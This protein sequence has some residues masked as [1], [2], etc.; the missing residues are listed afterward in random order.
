MD[1]MEISVQAFDENSPSSAL[2]SS[3]DLLEDYWAKFQSAQLNVEEKLMDEDLARV[4]E[5][6][7]VTE[8]SYLKS[9]SVLKGFLERRNRQGT[10]NQN[11]NQNADAG[12][13]NVKL[14]KLEVPTFDGSFT[15]WATFRD[16]FLSMV[17]NKNSIT[18][19]EKLQY[20]KPNCKGEAEDIVSEYQITDANYQGAWAALEERFDNKRLQVK[21]HLNQ[22]FGQPVMTTENVEMLRT[23]LRTTQKCLRALKSLGGPVEAWDWLLVHTTVMRLDPKTRRYWELIHTSKEVATWQ[24]LV[25]ALDNRCTALESESPSTKVETKSASSSTKTNDKKKVGSPSTARVLTAVSTKVCAICNGSHDCSN[26]KAFLDKNLDG[27]LDLV[28][29]HKLC[30]KCLKSNHNFRTCT[31]SRCGKCNKRHHQLLHDPSPSLQDGRAQ[32]VQ[33]SN[34][35]SVSSQNALVS[36]TTSTDLNQVLLSTALVKVRTMDGNWIVLRAFLDGGAQRNV[37][38]EDCVQ[39]LGLQRF[40]CNV[41]VNG[42][43]GVD[44]GTFKKGAVVPIKSCVDDGYRLSINAVV[45]KKIT[46][47]LPN[48]QFDISKWSYIRGL[49]LADP[50]FNEPGKID[51]LIGAEFFFSLLKNEP[52]VEGPVGYPIAQ[53]T[54]LGW[55]LSGPVKSSDG[56]ESSS[57]F[58]LTEAATAQ[59]LPAVLSKF[60]EL[61]EFPKSTLKSI[62]D[63]KCEEHFENTF[64]RTVD[65]RFIVKLPFKDDKLEFGDTRTSA[66]RRFTSLERRFSKDQRLQSD[67]IEQIRELESFAHAKPIDMV[68][69]NGFYLPHHAVVKPSRTTTKTRIVFDAAAKDSNGVSLNDK[70]MVG[71]RLQEDLLKL[72][73]RFRRHR[74]AVS[75]DVEKMF[76]Q[77]LV[78]LEDQQF[79]RFLWRESLQ[80]VLK[81]FILTTVVFGTSSAPF[82]AVKVLQKLAAL[83]CGDLTRTRSVILND[84]FMDD[85]LS[86][87]DTSEDVIQLVSELQS[88]LAKGKFPL[89]KWISNDN[90][91]LQSIDDDLK[92]YDNVWDVPLQDSCK[93]LGLRW[94]PGADVFGYQVNF[95]IKNVPAT[96]RS[97][98]SVI[99]S[100]YDPLG[101]LAPTVVKAKMIMQKIWR[102]GVDWDA[103]VSD[104][105]KAEWIE[106]YGGLNKINEIVVPR[107][108]GSYS[109]KC[110]ELHGFSDASNEAYSAVVYSRMKQDDGDYTTNI[111]IAKTRV[112][113][114]KQITT[115]HLE[116][117]GALL[118]TRLLS[119]AVDSLKLDK[120]LIFAWCDNTAV[121]DWLRKE[122]VYWKTFVA[123][124]VSEIQ[125]T[126]PSLSWRYVPSDQNPADCASRGIGAPTLQNHELWRN[127]PLWPNLVP[128]TNPEAEKEARKHVLASPVVVVDDRID[129]LARKFS[130]LDKSKNVF[131]YVMRFIAIARGEDKRFMG[132]PTVKELDD[133]LKFM[134]SLAQR[135]HFSEQLDALKVNGKL[136][137]KDKLL[138]LNPFI[139]NDGLLRV[140]GRLSNS[141]LKY[142]EKF[143]IIL[144]RLDHLTNMIIRHCHLVNF[145]AGTTL[146]LSQLRRTYWIVSARNLVKQYTRKCVKCCRVR[147]RT[148][149]QMMGDLPSVRVTS[150][151]PFFRSSVDYAGPI[152][153]KVPTTNVRKYD[154]T[155]GYIAVFICLATKCIHLEVVSDQT[156]EKY[157]EAYKRFTARRGVAREM[158]SDNGL[159]FV[160]AKNE[161]ARLK[162]M[163]NDQVQSELIR[164][165]LANDGT[166]W[167]MVPPY[168]PHFNGLCEAAVKS[169]KFHLH[170]ILSSTP[171]TFKEMSTILCQIEAILNSRPLIP[172]SDDVNDL[173]VLTPGHFLIGDQ[174]TAVPEPD[175][176]HIQMN[177]LDRFQL[178]Q[179]QVQE[180]WSKWNKDYLS[181]LQ[182][183]TKWKSPIENLKV[184]QLV[185]IKDDDS[186]P[187]K[188]LLA[189]VVK[190]KPGKDSRVRVAQLRTATVSGTVK[191][192]KNV[193]EMVAELKTH[194]GIAERSVNNLC[195]LPLD[196][197]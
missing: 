56:S 62:E 188:W 121:L 148:S 149:S 166:D 90:D 68:Q 1:R 124:R 6:M 141:L 26:C 2:Q 117:C 112:A 109:T 157:L 181:S 17:G 51:L 126:F 173:N 144:P 142:D 179:R 89:R 129:T 119:Y 37:V 58:V 94:H 195:I 135:K 87:G 114:I 38:T 75:A 125:S 134:I 147:G 86:G 57:L 152:Q 193:R 84:F 184:G 139:G 123:N 55:I 36:E 43:A 175:L 161:L 162:A 82:L 34:Q 158:R 116:L 74:V 145:H 168:T 29:K 71:P 52:Q 49:K 132:P 97:I 176:Q 7:Q 66:L 196:D 164:K 70:L 192:G 9:K 101:L 91:V 118:L 46:T 182:Q 136:K 61:E 47:D 78:A 64:S 154:I 120:T 8:A 13:G 30:Y 16:L 174:L 197:E 60:W 115:P 83:E 108:L 189:R 24:E 19:A 5:E 80:D 151:R 165:S 48:G 113:P 146:M 59:S 69:Q 31:E 20:L 191:P 155:K 27:R 99:A 15:N 128:P 100:L 11:R 137:K 171:F 98:L 177:R 93:A 133:A 150:H 25:T 107:W 194:Y 85:L 167:S 143:P 127:G 163:L 110:L 35:P 178:M 190:I 81:E 185:T 169:A 44:V 39:R 111:V 73:I 14:P 33:T 96:K 50:K 172:Q 42:I 170:R 53:S 156:T 22:L 104:E 72:L 160:G 63:R 79:Q 41:P 187:T 92:A 40:M 180:F 153:I 4:I 32:T 130:S 23:L 21:A 77:I 45:M 106:L 76:R 131:A 54:H 12:G 67:Y 138:S 102:L 10:A 3:L 159:N 105:I 103:P 18:D 95:D 122:P 140:G 183:R 88:V 65:G 186:P 28:H